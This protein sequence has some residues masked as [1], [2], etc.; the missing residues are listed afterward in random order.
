MLPTRS[1]LALLAAL[2]TVAVALPVASAGATVTPVVNNNKLTVTSGDAGEVITLGVEAGVLTVNDGQATVPTGLAAD[3]NA[4]IVV[5]GNGGDDTV[6]ASALGAASYGTLK[7]QGGENDDAVTGGARADELLG[8]GGND[9]LVGFLGDDKVEGGEGD[10]SM[11]WNNGDNSDVD[12]GGG[13][14]DEV[15]VNGK[16]DAKDRI[17]FRPKAG[18]AGRGIVERV[19]LIH[20]TI[21]FATSERVTINGLGG[22]DDVFPD[23][24][25]PTGFGA[26]TS[27]TVNGGAG[28]DNLFGG[29]GADQINGDAGGDA[30]GGGP[31]D[32]VISGGD[33][34][35]LLLGEGGN[36]RLVGDRNPD[37]FSG[38]GGEDVVVW[39]NGD[40]T[41]F[42]EGGEG[43]DRLEVNGSPTGGDQMN[44]APEGGDA[45]FERINLVPFAIFLF[46]ENVGDDSPNG[47]FEAVSVNGLGGED[48]FEVLPG[49][50]G[51][52]VSADGGSGADRLTGSQETDTFFGGSGA[53]MLAPGAGS[54]LAD[55]QE[56]D[57]ALFTRDHLGDLV[58]GGAGTD[59]AETD[60]TT[61]DAVSGIENLSATPQPVP[62][63]PGDTVALPP[64]IGQVAVM[65]AGRRLIARVPVTCPAAEAGGCRTTL[66]LET[67]KAARLGSVRAVLVLGSKSIALGAGQ[68]ATVSVRLA[69]GVEGLAK[70]G[71][72]AARA[73]LLSADASGN[74][75]SR[76]VF[77]TLRI[78]RG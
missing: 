27:L 52:E 20:F 13:G 18:E 65:R 2:A 26:L 69:P 4:E 6:D 5:Q 19:N 39:N 21:D 62:T 46:H 53:D 60:E 28:D 67:A 24:V 55:G 9:R 57:D 8:E 49:L 72:L 36:D 51:L 41:D 14:F 74:T 61:V 77:V 33:G 44:L 1:K 34:I 37:F 17:D 40:G 70:R 75:T 73:R 3:A 10:D 32:D 59:S 11:V 7:V 71:K 30:L 35:D 56:G 15:E 22:E 63:A 58:R 47:G 45:I 64:Q 25:A 76:S 31:G 68:K 54:D 38:E 50:A 48:R 16:A 66:T 23:G 12:N 43:F 78:P 42:A 29:D